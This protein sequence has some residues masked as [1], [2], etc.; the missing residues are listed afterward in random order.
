MKSSLVSHLLQFRIGSLRP[1]GTSTD[2]RPKLDQIDE[3]S[4][5]R[6]A[7]PLQFA[8]TP[9]RIRSRVHGAKNQDN[10]EH[11]PHYFSIF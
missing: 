7:S 11:S 2:S 6:K 3:V 1:H 5:V 10:D 4:C 9:K 8:N